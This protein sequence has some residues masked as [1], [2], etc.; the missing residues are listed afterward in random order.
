[1][2][3]TICD[4]RI[5]VG[6]PRL[7]LIPDFLQNQ[8]IKKQSIRLISVC[9]LC[10]M[11][12]FSASRKCLFFCTMFV[13]CS[14]WARPN[15]VPLSLWIWKYIEIRQKRPGGRLGLYAVEPTFLPEFLVFSK[16]V[17]AIVWADGFVPK[18]FGIAETKGQS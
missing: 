16:S 10:P 13:Q 4:L 1:L 6:S 14:A 3:F 9:Y 18:A 15:A 11:S 2:R 7:A 17:W 8:E 5:E 12:Q